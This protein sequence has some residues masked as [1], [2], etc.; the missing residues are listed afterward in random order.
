MKY[1]QYQNF[2]QKTTKSVGIIKKKVKSSQNE[3]KELYLWS[4]ILHFPLPTKVALGGIKG[5]GVKSDK[6]DGGKLIFSDG[7]AGNW[8][9]SSEGRKEEKISGFRYVYPVKALAATDI[10]DDK[11]EFTETRSY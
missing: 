10:N 6:V 5:M 2:K 3:K 9:K 7:I 11:K 4:P 8:H 1:V